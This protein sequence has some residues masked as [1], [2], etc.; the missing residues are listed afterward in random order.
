MVSPSSYAGREGYEVRLDLINTAKQDVTFRAGWWYERDQGGVKDYIEASTSIE[1]Y[2]PIA[3]WA[4]QVMGPHRTTPQPEYVLK[5]GE[6]L[7]VGWHS[8]GRRLKNK[9]TDPNSVQNPEF[10]FPGLYSVHAMLKINTSDR[11]VLLRSNEQLVSIGGSRESPKHSYGQLREVDADAKTATLGL[12]SLHKIE[13]GDEFQIRTGMTEF[14]R[15]TITQVAPESSTGVLE[16]LPRAGSN[17]TNPHPRIPERY[18]NAS[19]ISK[20]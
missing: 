1:T 14:W 11:P 18:M 3:P 20:K 8:D 6:V 12:G 7:S 16:P 4:G 10:P 19:L 5:A 17:S 2:P 13:P 9:V 15:L